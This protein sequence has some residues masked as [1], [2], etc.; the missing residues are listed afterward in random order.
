MQYKTIKLRL[1]ALLTAVLCATALQA[2]TTD[3][4]M[5]MEAEMLEHLASNERE[6]F[7]NASNRLKNAAQDA[8]DERLFYK[9]WSKQAVFEATH[10]DYVKAG[11]IAKNLTDYALQQGSNVGKYFSLHTEGTILLQKDDFEAAEQAFLK[12]LKIRHQFFPKESAAEDLR[13]LMKIAYMRYDYAKAEKYG[14]QL[15]AEPNLAPHHKGRTLARLSVIAFEED[16]VEEFNVIYDEMKRLMQT[17]GIRTLSLYTEVNYHIINKDYT[18][19]LRLCDWLSPDT[20]AERKALIYH[21]IGDNE[22]A[23]QY[24]A[25]YKHVFDSITRVSHTNT[26]SNLYLRM[27]NDR[28]RLERE[29]LKHQNERLNT[30]IYI[31]IGIIFILILIFFI[32]KGHQAIKLL[33]HDN[34]MLSYDK[35]DAE[36]ALED[37]NELSFYESKTELPLTTTVKVNDMCNKLTNA[38]QEH[39]RKGVNTLFLTELDEDIEIRTNREALEKLLTH[40]L[41][42][43]ARFTYR[44]T[45]KLECVENDKNIRFSV[46]DTSAGLGKKPKEYTV[47][48]FAEHGNT[49]RY[50]G[51]NFNICQSIT[52]LLKGRIWHDASYNEGTCFR[53]EI[54]KDPQQA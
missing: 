45:I 29:I 13:E 21:R 3:D 49:V 1:Q 40:L 34:M 44:G 9:A 11:E 37:L 38:T 54:P 25:L 16:N 15:L 53:V 52:R 35:K 42:Y 18:Q 8:G 4:L 36:K 7:Y 20:C 39:C 30:R 47:G 31:F 2:V 5:K 46:S 51:M 22:K 23:Y 26:V 27:N 33:R 14:H 17:N 43:A 32:W 12:A 48:M 10:Q 28:L 24:M 41:N 50:V 6:A 19:A